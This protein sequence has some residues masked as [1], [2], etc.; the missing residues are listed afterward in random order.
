MDLLQIITGLLCI[1]AIVCLAYQIKDLYHAFKNTDNF[2]DFLSNNDYDNQKLKIELD[3][4][5]DKHLLL[6]EE[7]RQLEEENKSLKVKLEGF[8]NAHDFI[9]R[10]NH[11]I[12]KKLPTHEWLYLD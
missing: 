3:I 8:K 4:L 7:N 9:V 5:E 10:E 2:K 1:G 11:K 6:Q 12:R